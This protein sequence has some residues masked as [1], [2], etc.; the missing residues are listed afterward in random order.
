MGLF[1]EMQPISVPLIIFGASGLFFTWSTIPFIFERRQG[2]IPFWCLCA[3]VF[4][5]V[6]GLVQIPLWTILYAG[7]YLESIDPLLA[8]LLSV[9]AFSAICFPLLPVIRLLAR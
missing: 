1:L 4:G 6:L 9:Q 2:E 5:F 3:S 8:Y 7:E